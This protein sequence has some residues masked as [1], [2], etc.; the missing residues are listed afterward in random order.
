M[1]C[2]LKKQP[3]RSQRLSLRQARRPPHTGRRG[4]VAVEFAVIAPLLLSI[5]VGLIELNRT[6]D[7]QNTLEAAAR[8]GGRFAS[9]DRTDMLDSG[10][11]AN[12]KLIQDVENFI[13]STGMDTEGLEVRVTDADDPSSDFNLDDPAN[14]L[15]LFQ[16]RIEV[17]YSSISYTPVDPL[18]DYTLSASVTFRNGRSQL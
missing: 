2:I 8:E 7:V 6:Y 10:Q 16:V 5:V 12:Q 18:S 14:D 4:A 11:T 9:I 1:M 15:Q 3:G 17:P 13:A